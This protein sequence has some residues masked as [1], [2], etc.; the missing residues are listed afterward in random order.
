MTSVKRKFDD[1]LRYAKRPDGLPV[2]EAT[3]CG[4]YTTAA[5]QYPL[6]GENGVL[7]KLLIG[8]G[9]MLIPVIGS[10]IASGYAL[11]AFKRVL[12]G[13]Y[14]LPE[15]DD[16]AGDFVNGLILTIGLLVFGVLMSISMV[17]IVTIPI[18]VIFGFPMFA[19]VVARYAATGDP[20]SFIDIFGAYRVL[21]D[22]LGDAIML[23]VGSLVVVVVMGILIGIGT[24]FLLIP[25]LM[26]TFALS[27]AVTFNAA[28]YGRTVLED[29]V[30]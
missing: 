8:G 18:V 4:V 15:W 23:L 17:F 5:M 19:Y 3:G 10:W 2:A 24:M 27:L 21:F 30:D 20:A 22:H 7:M 9:V 11:R 14:R 26:L 16:F 1:D 13:D 25:G 29:L 28:I 6:I 12:Q